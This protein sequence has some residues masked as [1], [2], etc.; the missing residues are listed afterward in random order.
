MANQ[1]GQCRSCCGKNTP[2]SQWLYNHP[3]FLCVHYL[4]GD[5]AALLFRFKDA[6]GGSALLTCFHNKRGREKRMWQTQHWLFN[7]LPRSV[8][9]HCCSYCVGQSKPHGYAEFKGVEK[10]IESY[11]KYVPRKERT[12]YLST[13]LIT[14]RSGT[15]WRG[16]WA[17][18]SSDM[19]FLAC[20]V[21]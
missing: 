3:Y 19:V 13:G 5:Q 17:E 15:G 20:L 9:H 10:H 6:V 14:A 8:S 7:H 12:G 2:K 21:F 1:S 16:A 4:V 18:C 11:S